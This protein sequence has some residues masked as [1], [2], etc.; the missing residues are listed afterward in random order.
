MQPTTWTE[1]QISI[2]VEEHG[3]G[4][5]RRYIAQ[6]INTRT[7]SSFTKSAICGKI[8]RMFPAAKPVKTEEEKA[9]TKARQ[10]ERDRLK[11]Q[12]KRGTPDQFGIMRRIKNKYESIRI[13]SANGNSNAMRVIKT[14]TTD[15]SSLRCVEIKCTTSLADVTGCRYPEGNGPFLFCNG[16]QRQGSSYC[17][18]HFSLCLRPPNANSGR[19]RPDFAAALRRHNGLT[20]TSNSVSPEFDAA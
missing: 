14:I 7:G 6:I 16:P 9:A 12:R 1:E 4:T 15:Q 18:P 8:D 2:L 5:R 19:E 13:V 10:R 20:P 11:K 3:I 17:E